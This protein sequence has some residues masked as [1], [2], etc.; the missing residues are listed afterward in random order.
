MG[1]PCHPI[2]GC[3]SDNGSGASKRLLNLTTYSGHR[4]LK[5]GAVKKYCTRAK[6]MT[7]FTCACCLLYVKVYKKLE[8]K[9]L[10]RGSWAHVQLERYGAY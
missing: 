4:A 8:E 10:K 3:R 5:P 1:L 6:R 9:V 2:W 7:D